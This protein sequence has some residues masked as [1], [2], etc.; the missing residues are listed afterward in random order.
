MDGWGQVQ[1]LGAASLSAPDESQREKS[2]SFR[3][4]SSSVLALLEVAAR[5]HPLP[6]ASAKPAA[7]VRHG[8]AP[9]AARGLDKLWMWVVAGC[10]DEAGPVFWV[11]GRARYGFGCSGHRLRA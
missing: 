8:R 1:L 5:S 6:A 9:C 4:A 2:S 7:W 11:G 3:I 10:Q